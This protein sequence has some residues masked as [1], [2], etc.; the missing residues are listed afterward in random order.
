[1]SCSV[2]GEDAVYLAADRDS[3]AL[4]CDKEECANEFANGAPIIGVRRKER[5]K[6]TQPVV[7]GRRKPV[8]K[9]TST[10]ATDEVFDTD[11]LVDDDEDDQEGKRVR[12]D[13]MDTTGYVVYL[14]DTAKQQYMQRLDMFKH[15]KFPYHKAGRIFDQFILD[16]KDCPIWKKYKILRF[17][18]SGSYGMVFEISNI[19]VDV[20]EEELAKF[21]AENTEY[22]ALKFESLSGRGTQ[23]MQEIQGEVAINELLLRL[24]KWETI[25]VLHMCDWLR[26]RTTL[27]KHLPNDIVERLENR[28]ANNKE[29]VGAMNVEQDW[30]MMLMEDADHTLEQF[31]KIQ[32]ELNKIN[33]DAMFQSVCVQVFCTLYLLQQKI[34]FK[35]GD[36][37]DNNVMMINAKKK[38]RDQRF[39]VYH[40]VDHRIAF[41]VPLYYTDGML[42]VLSD[43]GFSSAR[44]T[45]GAVDNI[46]EIKAN[47]AYD[48]YPLSEF[49]FVSNVQTIVRS[50]MDHKHLRRSA[51]LPIDA[52]EIREALFPIYKISSDPTFRINFPELLNKR[53]FSTFRYKVPDNVNTVEWLKAIISQPSNNNM[54][55]SD[56]NSYH[57]I[58]IHDQESLFHTSLIEAQRM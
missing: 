36:L 49:K 1:M 56:I 53:G 34:D 27:S 11:E 8:M 41:I 45:A 54:L 26:C 58:T 48:W 52:S 31:L 3:H 55:S 9:A 44:Y 25:N 46:V 33:M 12:E 5:K 6:V 32:S 10:L 17:L 15:E 35:H 23:G 2:C 22:Y 42:A 16:E 38:I 57:V 28:L 43:K 18:G 13:T 51:L 20:T 19:P 29:M 24:Q 37:S 40:L 7:K 47:I 14:A 30:Q 4:V 39:V 21:T 50:F